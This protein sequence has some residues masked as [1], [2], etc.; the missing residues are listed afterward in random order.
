MKIRIATKAWAGTRAA[1]TL[2]EADIGIKTMWVEL[3]GHRTHHALDAKVE[4][5]ADGATIV[6]IAFL[7]AAEMVL[8]DSGGEIIGGDSHLIPTFDG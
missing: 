3:D 2:N 6:T 7:A 4:T 1:D 5:H 8:L